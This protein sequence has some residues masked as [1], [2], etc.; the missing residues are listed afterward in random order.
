MNEAVISNSGRDR[1]P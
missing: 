1:F